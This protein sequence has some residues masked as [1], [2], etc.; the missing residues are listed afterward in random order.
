MDNVYFVE[1]FTWWQH[2]LCQHESSNLRT[3]STFFWTN[4]VL[5]LLGLCLMHAL[6]AV[7]GTFFDP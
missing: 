7:G 2:R 4:C 3:K 5:G 1:A 6:G